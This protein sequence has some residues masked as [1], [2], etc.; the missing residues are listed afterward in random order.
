MVDVISNKASSQPIHKEKLL[1]LA[2]KLQ[3]FKI[4]QQFWETLDFQRDIYNLFCLNSIPCRHS[5]GLLTTR[6]CD[7]LH[8]IEAAVGEGVSWGYDLPTII[9][10]NNNKNKN[11]LQWKVVFSSGI[12][13]SEKESY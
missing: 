13:K 12:Q 5:Y 4:P 7:A 6:P 2:V 1:K 11:K 8:E 3:V 10:A 9:V